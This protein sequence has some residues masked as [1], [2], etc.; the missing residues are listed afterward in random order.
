MEKGNFVFFSPKFEPKYNDVEIYADFWLV[1]KSTKCK[2]K[3]D[4]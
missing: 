1:D 2:S 4:V 3:V